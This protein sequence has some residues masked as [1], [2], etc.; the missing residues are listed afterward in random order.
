MKPRTPQ[1]LADFFQL[2]FF[3]VH[4]KW[5][6]SRNRPQWTPLGYDFRGC[7]VEVIMTWYDVLF[8]GNDRESLHEPKRE[9]DT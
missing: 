7:G 8:M 4:K 6:G 5:Y 9:I 1:H 3:R 2:Y